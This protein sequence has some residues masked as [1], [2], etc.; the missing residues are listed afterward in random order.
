MRRMSFGMGGAIVVASPILLAGACGDSVNP[1]V[2]AD[3]STPDVFGTTLEATPSGEILGVSYLRLPL[4]QSCVQRLARV[5]MNA[6]VARRI[7]QHGPW[8]WVLGKLRLPAWERASWKMLYVDSG[9]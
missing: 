6:R 9:P 1:V 5:C 4:D 8:A 3:A 2:G 7:T